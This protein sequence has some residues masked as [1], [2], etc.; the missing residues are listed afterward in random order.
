MY[1]EILTSIDSRR[2]CA[3]AEQ[4][5]AAAE[6]VVL[7]AHEVVQSAPTLVSAAWLSMAAQLLSAAHVERRK[8]LR[9]KYIALVVVYHILY[10]ISLLLICLV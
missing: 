7:T 1:P 8:A 2:R 3:A 5:C 4:A 10:N 9:K 6:E